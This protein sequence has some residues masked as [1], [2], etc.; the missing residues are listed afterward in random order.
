MK[1]GHRKAI[2]TS[3]GNTKAK[4]ITSNE[5]F[6]QTQKNTVKKHVA[7]KIAVGVGMKAAQKVLEKNGNKEVASFVEIA[8]P[9]LQLGVDALA[10]RGYVK[11]TKNYNRN[12][13]D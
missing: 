7:A 10:I 5:Q 12:S 3:G 13:Q 11:N 4:R 9:T 8:A 6:R 1:W 2:Q